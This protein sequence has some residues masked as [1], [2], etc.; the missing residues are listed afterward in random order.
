M[1][2]RRFGLMSRS[3]AVSLARAPVFLSHSQPFS[4]ILSHSQFL[5]VPSYRSPEVSSSRYTSLNYPFKQT[6]CGTAKHK[7]KAKS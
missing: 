1:F 7:K 5:V 2:G 3:P 4:A 6:R